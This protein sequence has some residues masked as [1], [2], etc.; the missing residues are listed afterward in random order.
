MPRSAARPDERTTI[1]DAVDGD[2]AAQRAL[3]ER[4][5]P[6]IYGLCRATEPAPDDCY[7]EIW[8]KALRALPRF[9]PAG[10]AALSTWLYRIAHHHLVDRQRRHRVRAIIEPLRSDPASEGDVDAAVLRAQR[11][12]RLRAALGRL[13]DPQ[14]RAIVFH[15][16]EE[17][18]VA[19]VA[20]REGVPTG[21][22]K[23]RLHQGRARLLA[24][25]G[26]RL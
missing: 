23:S 7:Q 6:M 14:R 10:P 15:Y 13:P 4:H 21:T 24:L 16:I 20:Q 9:D 1:Q 3:I 5:G 11:S 19:E 12:D 25:L 2:R 17:I 22:V 8:E 18:S 26:G